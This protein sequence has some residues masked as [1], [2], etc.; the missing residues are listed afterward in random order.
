MTVHPVYTLPRMKERVF[1]GGI[2]VQSLWDLVWLHQTQSRPPVGHTQTH[3]FVIEENV[4][5]LYVS[6]G[7]SHTMEVLLLRRGTDQSGAGGKSATVINIANK[8][9]NI[10]RTSFLL[11][12]SNQ[13]CW[14]CMS[15]ASYTPR[16]LSTAERTCEHPSLAFLRPVL[17][18]GKERE[19]GL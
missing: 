6:V 11:E 2:M 7:D 13:A 12:V 1:E 14:Y 19:E 18:N 8:K 3:T 4:L 9:G 17:R 16:L 10:D 15:G 5:R